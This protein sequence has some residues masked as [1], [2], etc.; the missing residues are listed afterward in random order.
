MLFAGLSSYGSDEAY[1]LVGRVQLMFE[2]CHFRVRIVHT[3]G[4][5]ILLSHAFRDAQ[6][7]SEMSIVP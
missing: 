6:T 2:L 5:L 7:V 1:F 4:M 3:F